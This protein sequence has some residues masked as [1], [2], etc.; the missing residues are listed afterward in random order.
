MRN[1]STILFCTLSALVV[2]LFAADIAVGSVNIPLRDIWATLTGGECD[3]VTAKIII[4]I[5][6]IKAFVAILAG[7]ALSVSGLQMQTL[8]RNPL[9]GPYVL[10]VSSGASLGVALF[11]L[12]APLL[13]FTASPLLTTLG[14]AGAAWLGAAAILAL[15]ASVSRRIKDIMVILIL[16]M[17]IGSA[18][19]AIVQILQYLSN[20]E[21]LKS[22]IVW[23]MGSLGDVTSSQLLLVAPA[24]IA[25]L[26]IAISVIKPMNMLLLGEP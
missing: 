4:D 16:G 18:V 13:G 3:A 6:L 26:I 5:R 17:M 15:V 22:F 9:A 2:L 25:G 12:G 1:R 19:S 24:I 14:T 20:E 21:A 10:G 8:F 11:I 7:A 23:T